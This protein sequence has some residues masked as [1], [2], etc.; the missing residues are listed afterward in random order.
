M[1]DLLG[2]RARADVSARDREHR[3]IERRD[4]LLE[5]ALVPIAQTPDEQGVIGDASHATGG[6]THHARLPREAHPV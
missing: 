1:H 2:H 6:A 3:R 5:R 4:E